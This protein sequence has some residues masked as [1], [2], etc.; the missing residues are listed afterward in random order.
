MKEQGLT[1]IALVITIIIL[2][3]LAGVSIRLTVGENGVLT[4]AGNVEIEYNKSEVLEQLNIVLTEIYL[5]AYNKEAGKNVENYY[6]EEKILEYLKEK[7]YIEDYYD[8][9]N[10]IVNDRYFVVIPT[11]Q[12]NIK[13]Y[14]TGKNGN[15]GGNELDIFYVVKS[16]K[17][18]VEEGTPNFEFKLYY[19]PLKGDKNE[20]QEI[21]TLQ[22]KQN[23]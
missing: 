6:N 16:E 14:G 5:E 2:L 18:D 4:K 21:G 8:E 9:N 12:R 10:S 7:N 19:V 17:E 22:V 20:P 1:L 11:L 3:I 13:K 15:N 23:L